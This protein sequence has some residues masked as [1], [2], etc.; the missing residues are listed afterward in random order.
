VGVDWSDAGRAAVEMAADLA[1]GRRLPLRLVHALEPPLYPVR[2]V[3]GRVTDVELMLRKSAERLLDEAVEVLQVARPEVTVVTRLAHGSAV[4]VLVEES[5]TADLVVVGS[6]GAGMLADVLVGSTTLHLAS[7]AACP[8][9]A[10]PAPPDLPADRHGV[11][12]GVDGSAVSHDA[13]AFAFRIASALGE[14]VLALHSW[15]HPMRLGAGEKVPV[16]YETAVVQDGELLVTAESLAG[17]SE[18]FPD[19]KVEQRVVRAHPVAALVDAARAARLLVVGT[20]GRGPV[21]SL[22]LGSV[23]HGVLHRATV[24][25]AVVPPATR[26]HPG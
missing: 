5:R 23:S 12:V 14:D 8:V 13:V 24:P 15:T 1:R 6:R 4:E 11:V 22:L 21:R 9:I 17:W 18:Q 2:P 25:V 20:R 3:V 7:L 16:V 10:V 26:G 19:V